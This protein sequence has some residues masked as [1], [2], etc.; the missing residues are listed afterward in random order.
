MN[1]EGSP[2]HCFC[3]LHLPPMQPFQSVC[4]KIYSKHKQDVLD[5]LSA[6]EAMR[7]AYNCL[8]YSKQLFKYFCLQLIS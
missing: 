3:I 4:F 5:T 6:E 7:F 1:Q 8:H 2:W